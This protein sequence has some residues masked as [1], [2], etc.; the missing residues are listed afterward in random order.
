MLIHPP[1]WPDLAPPF[2]FALFGHVKGLLSEKSFETREDLLSTVE[3]IL[4]P[5]EMSTLS[6]VFLEW[7]TTLERCIQT[8]GDYVG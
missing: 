1:Y 2:D 6:E 7:M 3:V 8:N 4:G 5:L